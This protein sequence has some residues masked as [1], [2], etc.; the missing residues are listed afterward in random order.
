MTSPYSRLSSKQ[1]YRSGSPTA[2]QA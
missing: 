2:I 1:G